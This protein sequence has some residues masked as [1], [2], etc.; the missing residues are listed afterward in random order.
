MSHVWFEI[1][2][3][4]GAAFLATSHENIGPNFL[5]NKNAPLK[6]IECEIFVLIVR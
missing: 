6:L 2:S 4:Y 5:H 3:W 1:Y